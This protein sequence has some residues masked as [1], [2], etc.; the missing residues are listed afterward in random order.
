[1]A[2]EIA[3]RVHNSGHWSIEGSFCSQFENHIRAILDLPLGNAYGGRPAA[4]VNLIG[5]LPEIAGILRAVPDAHIHFYG[6]A[7]RPNR[8]VG[9]ITVLADTMD[10]LLGKVDALKQLIGE[11]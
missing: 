7:P 5:S 11:P 6:K 4:M 1:M 8:K 2:N 3:P 10:S 9:H